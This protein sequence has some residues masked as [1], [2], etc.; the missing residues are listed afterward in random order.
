MRNLKQRRLK[1]NPLACFQWV[2]LKYIPTFMFWAYACIWTESL[3]TQGFD[4]RLPAELAIC[5]PVKRRLP[6][7]V[8]F[9]P[10]S[11]TPS[12]RVPTGWQSSRSP[13]WGLSKN[14]PKLIGGFAQNCCPSS[15]QIWLK[16]NKKSVMNMVRTVTETTLPPNPEISNPYTICYVSST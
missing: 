6:L 7:K 13:P 1:Q 3:K 9:K 14:K 2:Q 5:G 10:D 15:L 16:W 12:N 4:P 11:P 8:A